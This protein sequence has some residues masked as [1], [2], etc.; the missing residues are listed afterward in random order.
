M[1]S[2]A[3]SS[4]QLVLAIL[5]A[6]F[7]LAANDVVY[8]RG[9]VMMQDGSAPGRSVEIVLS[10]DGLKPFR[11]TTAG[12]KGDFNWKVERDEFD[13]IARALPTSGLDLN[14][15]VAIQGSCSLSAS[16]AG[17]E[18]TAIPLA[19]FKIPK[20]QKLAPLVLKAKPAEH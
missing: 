6:A 18:S 2:A 20:D 11:L 14:E 16:R 8:L 13:H 19:N 15:G 3:N 12:K 17:Y 1:Q 10:C 9:R 7:P 5:L 4:F